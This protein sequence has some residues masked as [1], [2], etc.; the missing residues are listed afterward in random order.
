MSVV[1]IDPKG[2]VFTVEAHIE[3]GSFV[4]TLSEHIAD[5]NARTMLFRFDDENLAAID[6]INRS[7]FDSFILV[8]PFEITYPKY[9]KS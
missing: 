2:K 4:R 1:Y 5:K 3:V 7:I 9:S 6:V 8:F